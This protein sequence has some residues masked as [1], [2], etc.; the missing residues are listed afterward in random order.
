MPI[1]TVLPESSFTLT[2]S[3]EDQAE[4]AVTLEPTPQAAMTLHVNPLGPDL[5]LTP[6]LGALESI[7]EALPVDLSPVLTAVAPL[8]TSSDLANAIASTLSALAAIPTPDVSA[9]V[10]PLATTD[11]VTASEV[12]VRADIAAI[13][14]PD[15]TATLERYGAATATDVAAVE[16]G[17][18]AW[19][20]SASDYLDG[21]IIAARDSLAALITPLAKKTDVDAGIAALIAA[22]PPA[23][24]RGQVVDMALDA[25]GRV[26][27]GYAMVNGIPSLPLGG[28][29][30]YFGNGN[31]AT[32]LGTIGT[33]S[34]KPIARGSAGVIGAFAGTMY[35]WDQVNGYTAAPLPTHPGTGS[36]VLEFAMLPSGRLLS[37]GSTIAANPTASCYAGNFTTQTWNA[38]A[39][40]PVG[41]HQV[42]LSALADGR[43][44]CIG[45]ATGGTMTASTFS[46]RLDIF[47]E[48]ANSWTNGPAAPVRGVG[49]AALLPNGR[50]LWVPIRISDG[51]TITVNTNRA[52]LL[53]PIALT[54]T[55]TD[56][57]PAGIIINTSTT[58][59]QDDVGAL[60][61]NVDGPQSACRFSAANARGYMWTAVHLDCIAP[62]ATTYRG[63][64]GAKLSNGQIFLPRPS[65]P[66]QMVNVQFNPGNQIVQA[67][68]L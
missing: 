28:L 18:R 39:P 3:G 61:I 54:W 19:I 45:G 23:V 30:A 57:L 40:L 12:R 50:V 36:V 41:R 9:A 43:V 25:N 48:A 66:P 51:T 13:P 21:K 52:F 38:V 42:A 68:K 55:E 31:R 16:T 8:A 47:D 35:G 60:L 10:A 65:D 62:A 20:T 53:D 49:Q 24:V 1:L 37:A 22:L 2:V 59:V 27:D 4:G 58:L 33:G 7:S 29:L 67:R 15:V 26:P 6:L 63:G 44:A 14:A 11:Q 46:D 34:S 17:L 32:G 56:P 5:D 64:I